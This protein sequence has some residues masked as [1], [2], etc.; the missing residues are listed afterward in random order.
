MRSADYARNHSAESLWQAV[1]PC[2]ETLVHRN[3]T[4]CDP[5][6]GTGISRTAFSESE[7]T[8]PY[9]ANLFQI[10]H[11]VLGR[12]SAGRVPQW[13]QGLI[14]RSR[15]RGF[16]SSAYT[17][18]PLSSL[19]K[20]SVDFCGRTSPAKAMSRTCCMRTGLIRNAT[21]APPWRTCFK[22]SPVSRK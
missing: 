5:R 10:A 16:Y 3:E 1:S 2:S 8:F 6:A 22:A 15:P 9:P 4:G 14:E 17:H 12:D 18:N 11:N 20:K 19:G 21:F 13:K 7:H